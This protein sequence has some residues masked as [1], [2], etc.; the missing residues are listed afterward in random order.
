MSVVKV[1][2]LRVSYGRTEAV[3]GISF[4]IPR[5]EVFG[6][7]GPDGAGKSATINQGCGWQEARRCVFAAFCDDPYWCVDSAWSPYWCA[8]VTVERRGLIDAYA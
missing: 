7:I 2:N 5:G 1:D 6:F 8:V 3:R 4:E